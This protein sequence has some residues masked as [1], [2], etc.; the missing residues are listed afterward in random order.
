MF[1]LNDRH[2][3]D[4]SCAP[5]MAV[6]HNLPT[7]EELTHILGTDSRNQQIRGEIFCKWE[8]QPFAVFRVSVVS[9]HLTF[10][11][12][13]SKFRLNMETG[14]WNKYK[15]KLRKTVTKLFV[16]LCSYAFPS[17]NW[18]KKIISFCAS[19]LG[20]SWNAI[21]KA[22]S[23]EWLWVISNPSAALHKYAGICSWF[24][25]YLKLMFCRFRGGML[26]WHLIK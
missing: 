19:N 11:A 7:L 16:N 6:M 24:L 22:L 21:W 10:T 9:D 23:F 25:V 18:K 17:S 3:S 8:W 12:F 14:A 13:Q 15:P 26:S 4:S 1:H 2:S 20:R 5:K